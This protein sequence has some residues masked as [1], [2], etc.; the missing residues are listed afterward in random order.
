MENLRLDGAARARTRSRQPPEAS[1]QARND[2]D[3]SPRPARRARSWAWVGVYLVGVGL[4]LVGVAARAGDE[5]SPPAAKKDGWTWPAAII[6][7]PPATR[8]GLLDKLRRPD[9]ILWDAAAFDRWRATAGAAPIG[10][11]RPGAGVVT[12][13]RVAVRADRDRSRA[14]LVVRL[15]VVLDADAPTRVPIGLD[16]LVLGRAVESGRDLAVASLGEG[17]GWTVELA[18]RGEHAVEVETSAPIRPVAPGRGVEVAIP[19]A[20][21]TEVEV[22]AGAPLAAARAG[23]GE[24]LPVEGPRA[25]GHL[26]PR[27]RL[28]LTWQEQEPAAA[29]A[30]ALLVARGELVVTAG[31][32]AIQTQETWSI[33]SIRGAARQ[34]VFRVPPAEDVAEV[35]VDGHPVAANRPGTDELIVPLAVPIVGPEAGPEARAVTIALRTRRARPSDQ[36]GDSTSY[37]FGGH[38]IVG[39]RSEAGVIA[40]SRSEATTIT[41]AEVRGVRRVDPAV[42]LPEPLR[43]RPEGWLAFEFAAQPFDL[44]LRV[45]PVAPRFEVNARSTVVLTGDRAEVTTALVGRVWQG[46]LFDLRILVPP[47]VDFEPA[48]PAPDGPTIRSERK[49]PRTLEAAPGQAPASAEVLTATFARPVAAGETFAIPLKGVARLG[50]TSEGAPGSVGLFQPLGTALVA[51]EVALVSARD[52]RFDLAEG[53][54]TRFARLDPATPPAGWTWPAGFDPAQGASPTWLRADAAEAVVPV[55]VAACPRTIR[56]RS[57][58]ALAFDRTGADAVAE[59]GG[60]VSNGTVAT[61]EIALPPEIGDRWVAESGEG[62][63]REPL[64][65][66]PTTGWRRYRLRLAE[67]ANAFQVRIRYRLEFAATTP[68]ATGPNPRLRIRPIRVLDGTSLGQAVRLSAEPDVALAVLAPGWDETS[69]SAARGASPDLSPP[70]RH[71]FEHPGDPIAAAI[72]VTAT[73]GKLA[74]LPTLVASRLWLLSTQ[75][76]GGELATSTQY[77]LEAHGRSVVLRLPAGSRWVRGVAGTAELVAGDVEQLD[78]DTYRITL[79]AAIGSGPFPL[80]VDSILDRPPTDGTWPAPELVGGVVQQTA[81]E[82]SLLGTRAGVGVPAGWTDENV[83]YRDGLL[84]KRRPRRAESDLALWLADGAPSAGGMVNLGP[85]V[86]LVPGGPSVAA[87]NDPADG[88]HAY[89]FS[90]PGPPTPLRF[91]TWARP[92]LLLVCSGPVL[93]VGLLILARRPPPRWVAGATLGVG[94]A[95]V[96]LVEPNTGLLVAE[97][98]SVGFALAGIAALIHAVLER[99][100]R[101]APGDG[102]PALIL[103]PAWEGRSDP[104]ASA[105]ALTTPPAFR[106]PPPMDEWTVIHQY[107]AVGG[108]TGEFPIPPDRA[109][110]AGSTPEVEVP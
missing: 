6:L 67:A 57:T 53:G 29:A 61:L 74:D 56:H 108:S 20:A 33:R 95:W 32:D 92:T 88:H 42:D 106:P 104:S 76:P 85:G 107:P 40:V 7:E 27:S 17:R 12:A 55:R 91:A 47:G 45:E 97:S 69:T 15:R 9:L 84:W 62:L 16:G 19:P 110:A 38:P 28:E 44:G 102:E 41:P 46:R 64:D 58:L 23:V 51:T 93:L 1:L 105:L 90:R 86:R 21:M 80:R 73:L 39:A 82:L 43:S 63:D 18:G 98:A 66:D 87:P 37:G 30:P 4:G 25:A 22:V 13:I 3:L 109:T 71:S 48:E 24:S 26:G 65:L 101:S 78:P 60:D 59:M 81:W 94:L 75:M 79:P 70:A 54:A 2:S 11:D 52:R 72:E 100:A 50:A 89:L 99:R 14:D 34:V 31:L 103:E 35:Q 8:D 10:A 49:R 77:R 83:W 5:P 36:G 68:G 96:A